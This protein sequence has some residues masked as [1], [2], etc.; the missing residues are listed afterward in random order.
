M[1]VMCS[2]YI[3]TVGAMIFFQ[4]VSG[5]GSTKAAFRLELTALVIYAIYCTV[6]AG[7]LKLD[8]AICWSAE[9]VYALA[10]LIICY[11]YLRG[12]RWRNRK[13]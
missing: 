2:S 1:V 11:A 10:L 4:G 5:T 6:T 7:I 9:H 12:N 8:V 3:F 13:I